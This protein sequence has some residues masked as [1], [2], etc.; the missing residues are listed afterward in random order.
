MDSIFAEIADD[1]SPPVLA[2]D[3]NAGLPPMGASVGVVV[4]GFVAGAAA[5]TLLDKVAPLV[6]WLTAAGLCCGLYALAARFS[7]DQPTRMRFLVLLGLGCLTCF[8]LLILGGENAPR[9]LKRDALG[10][11]TFLLLFFGVFAV[12]TL[13]PLLAVIAGL[14]GE[15]SADARQV[16]FRVNSF[17]IGLVTGV[18]T[19]MLAATLFTLIVW[20]SPEGWRAGA[21]VAFALGSPPLFGLLGTWSYVRVLSRWEVESPGRSLLQGLETLRDRTG[22]SF[23]R[24]LSLEDGFG[25]GRVCLVVAYPNRS[26]LVMSESI[27]GLLTADQLLAVLAHEAAHVSLHHVRRKLAWGVIGTVAFLTAAVIAQVLIAP[28]V[29]R[30]LRFVGILVVVLPMVMLRGLFDTHVVRRHEAEAD[31]FAVSVAGAEPLLSALEALS[32]NG[33]TA[34]AIHNRW[35]THG[36]WE[37]RAARIRDMASLGKGAER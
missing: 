23:D 14:R 32:F 11:F 30:S 35:T 15:S 8:Y 36:T 4:A 37:A 27:A 24:V 18:V 28:W 1:G 26:V 12:A 2:P 25:G 33:P 10:L 21:L 34:A 13:L 3:T 20:I 31:E 17:S 19:F 5:A 9:P 16:S 22:F 6:A 29:P 7:R